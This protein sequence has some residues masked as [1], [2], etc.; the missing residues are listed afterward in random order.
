LA[1]R[2][3]TP[4]ETIGTRA[5]GAPLG[6]LARLPTG[7]KLVLWLSAALLP[8]ALIAVVAAFQTTRTA[9]V[10]NRT[11]LR[12]AAAESARTLSIELSGDMNALRTA[13]DAIERDPADTLS[14]AR[15]RGVFA[16]DT[17]AGGTLAIYDA[18]GRLRCGSPLAASA[19]PAGGI[20]VDI[21]PNGVILTVAGSTGLARGSAYFPGVFLSEIARPSGFVPEYGAVLSSGDDTL[22]LRRF[23]RSMLERRDSQSVAI[24]IDSLMLD[25]TMAGAPIT[26][27]VILAM[28]LPIVMWIAAVGIGWLVV[29]GILIRPLRRLQRSV[30]G[31]RPGEPFPAE[32]AYRA[33]AHEIRD[34][35]G[36][37]RKLATTVA[38]HEADLAEGLVSQTKLTREV[39]H[40]V[41]NNLQVIASLI[42]FHARS[43][44]N[45][46]VTQ[47]YASI[48]RRVDALAVVHRNH[49]AEMEVNRGLSLRSVIGELAANLRATAPDTM[50]QGIA[51]DIEPFL[52]SQDTAVAVAFLI[53]ELV[54]LAM[55]ADGS[56]DVRISVSATDEPDRARLRISGPALVEG[57]TLQHKLATRYG[58]V[59]EGLARQLRSKLHHEP[60]VGAFEIAIAVVGRD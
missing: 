20:G 6:A 11:R 42:N 23:D 53:T 34:L 2:E 26:S 3:A 50:R 52:V 58:R 1:D 7:A 36:A 45:P 19:P 21:R 9:D 14:C 8:L 38:D 60:L 37:F 51:L 29:D 33:P 13:M 10:E 22:V 59:I 5:A 24:G 17:A 16:S 15:V 48:Q 47:A 49:F 54:E 4:E 40:R 35:D 39:H 32:G 12:V 56:G 31:Y 41:K 55:S 46:D 25:M 44:T 28:L 57:E 43:A 18:A 30:A 27:P